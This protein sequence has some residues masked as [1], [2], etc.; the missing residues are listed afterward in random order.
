MSIGQGFVDFEALLMTALDFNVWVS[1]IILDMTEVRESLEMS[2]FRAR[3]VNSDEIKA[4]V[5]PA[6]N[7]K[8]IE[9]KNYIDILKES[10]DLNIS[11]INAIGI[12][13]LTRS[14]RFY[15]TENVM[16]MSYLLEP[17]FAVPMSLTK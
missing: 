8:F 7:G 6:S 9:T 12:K 3:L 11:P 13:W 16:N 1:A 14:S 10:I 2:V 15:S 4:R 5:N 17:N